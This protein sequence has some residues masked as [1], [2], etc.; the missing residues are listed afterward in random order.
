[1]KR[2]PHATPSSAEDDELSARFRAGEAQAFESVVTRY[3]T[4]VYL[5][6]RRL[7]PSHADA[8]EA[9]QVAFVRAWRSRETF[10]GD[11]ALR[12]W[13]IRI[14]LNVAKSMRSARREPTEGPEALSL[15]PT[16]ETASDER[17]RHEE[18]RREVRCSVAALPPRQREAVLLKVFG[19][20]TYREVAETMHLSEGAVKAH[21]HQAVANLRRRFAQGRS[22]R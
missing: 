11:A 13:L 8:D 15:V 10:R 21:L 20:L 6:A 18:L 9:A 2:V 22:R 5:M 19:E 3:R 7:L 17:L 14:V 4:A 1:M 12:T 16:G